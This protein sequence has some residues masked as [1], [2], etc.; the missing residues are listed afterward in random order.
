ME[1]YEKINMEVIL[2][3]SADII[4]NESDIELPDLP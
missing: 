3:E 1:T 4:T 2:F